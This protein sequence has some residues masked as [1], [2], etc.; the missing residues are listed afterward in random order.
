MPI[1]LFAIFLKGPAWLRLTVLAGFGAL[2]LFA[3]ASTAHTFRLATERTAPAH[4]THR[5]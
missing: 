2:L 4:V 5:R 1:L 3:F